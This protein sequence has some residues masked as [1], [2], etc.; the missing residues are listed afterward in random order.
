MATATRKPRATIVNREIV[1]QAKTLLQELPEKTKEDLSLREAVD[2]L[3]DEIKA[4]IARGYNYED[5]AKIL[6]QQGIKISSLTLKNYVPLGKRQ[7]TK[8][9]TKRGKKSVDEAPVAENSPET[10]PP[11]PVAVPE[12]AP[13]K[14]RRGRAKA[15]ESSPAPAPVAAAAE[16]KTRASRTRQTA[17]KETPK[18]TSTRGR[19][20]ATAN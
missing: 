8:T 2:H 6:S 16:P 10:A 15:A 18:K 1:G 13:A 19:K 4:A 9:K 20:K 17:T 7:L 11:E 14:A 3:E 12:V 5:I